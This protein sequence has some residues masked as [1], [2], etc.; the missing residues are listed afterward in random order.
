MGKRLANV[1]SALIIVTIILIT[2]CTSSSDEKTP[3][4]PALQEEELTLSIQEKDTAIT[5]T[6]GEIFHIILEGNITTGY[7][8]EVNEIDENF[9]QQQGEMEYRER[10]DSPASTAEEPLVGAPG[11]FAFTFKALQA[12]DTELSLIYHRTFEPDVAPLDEFS[13]TIH[14]MD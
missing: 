13:I 6:T 2:A 7:T 12:G 1:V 10:E 14:I 8:W 9:L 4:E 11:E 5:I 3:D